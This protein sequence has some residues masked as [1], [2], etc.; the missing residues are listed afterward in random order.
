MC[1]MCVSPYSHIYLHTHL[2][3][4]PITGFR[5]IEII[6]SPFSPLPLKKNQLSDF[7]L[8]LQVKENV[9][10]LSNWHPYHI[11]PNCCWPWLCFYWHESQSLTSM[12]AISRDLWSEW[13]LVCCFSLMILLDIVLAFLPPV[14]DCKFNSWNTGYICTLGRWTVFSVICHADHCSV[15]S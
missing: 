10:W 6:A 13:S 14:C 11:S 5:R 7:V 12:A 4:H 15:L 1:V 9:D 2:Y 3:P 8:T